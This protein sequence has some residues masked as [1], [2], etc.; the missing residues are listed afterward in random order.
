MM[1][2]SAERRQRNDVGLASSALKGAGLM[3]RDSRMRDAPAAGPSSAAGSHGPRKGHA[4]SGAHT[5]KKSTHGHRQRAIDPFKTAGVA[6][7]NSRL[8]NCFS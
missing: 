2:A 7:L 3:D 5:N 6:D 1:M 4:K 8:V